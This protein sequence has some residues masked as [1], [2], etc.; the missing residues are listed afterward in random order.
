[1]DATSARRAQNQ[2]SS[3]ATIVV[4]MSDHLVAIEGPFTK[5]APRQW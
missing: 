4:E 2:G 3:H 1:M 5:L